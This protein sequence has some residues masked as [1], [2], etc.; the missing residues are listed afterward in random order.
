MKFGV[1]TFIWTES[2]T[3]ANLP[4]LP[5]IKAAGFDGIE[6]FLLK[7]ADFAAADIRRGC[8]ANGLECTICAVLSPDVSIISEDP[9]VRVAAGTHMQDCVQAAAEVGA[10][11]IAGPLY[12]P[13]EIGRAHV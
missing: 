10:K 5:E 12:S 8:E 6:V 7:P 2:F 1:N 4:L 3:K 9:G 11:V 13:V